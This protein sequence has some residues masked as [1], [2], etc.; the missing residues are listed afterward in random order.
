MS[1]QG[2]KISLE[3]SLW[4]S[5]TVVLTQSTG[6]AAARRSFLH[7]GLFPNSPEPPK[8]WFGTI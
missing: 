7:I 1:A 8:K 2:R 5:G 6:M 4:E 3:R